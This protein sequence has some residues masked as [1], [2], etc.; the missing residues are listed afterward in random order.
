MDYREQEVSTG[1]PGQDTHFEDAVEEAA[2]L[3]VEGETAADEAADSP[4]G[5]SPESSEGGGEPATSS[6][7]EV[8]GGL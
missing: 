7:D 4:S 2:R 6:S 8:P 1:R 5:S 3:E